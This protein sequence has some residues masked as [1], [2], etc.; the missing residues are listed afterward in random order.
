[1]W[2]EPYQ[3]NKHQN[4]FFEEKALIYSDI[5]HLFQLLNNPSFIIT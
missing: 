1:M 4:Q 5:G 2:K 3:E